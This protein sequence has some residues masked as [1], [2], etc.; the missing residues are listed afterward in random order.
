MAT[1]E[2]EGKIPQLKKYLPSLVLID[3][4]L[5]VQLEKFI[6]RMYM[7]R[8]AYIHNADEM[9]LTEDNVDKLEKIV[10]RLILQMTRSSVNYNSTKEI[11]CAIDKNKFNP[12]LD[13]LP[14]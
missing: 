14:T 5:S 2:R 1:N 4:K 9:A 11:C 7:I 13:N 6:E 3:K 10:Y 12:F 8:S